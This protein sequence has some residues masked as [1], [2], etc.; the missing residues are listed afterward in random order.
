MR[1][2]V[3]H[4][5]FVTA[6][7]VA[8]ALVLFLAYS[9]T[10]APREGDSEGTAL[11][12]AHADCEPRDLGGLTLVSGQSSGAPYGSAE[13]PS[14][15]DVLEQGL[16]QSGASPVHLAVRG[17][18]GPVRCDWRGIARTPAQREAA[19]RFWLDLDD[20]AP[21]PSPAEAEADGLWKS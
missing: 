18:A 5:P 13:T 20:T 14:L 8:A 4:A 7:I 2:V 10:L 19:I 9:L 6:G 12:C 11:P 17:T 3:P 16:Q 15:E 21:L 1:S